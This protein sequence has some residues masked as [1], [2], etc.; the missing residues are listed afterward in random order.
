[1]TD[2]NLDNCIVENQ[3][4]VNISIRSHNN[5]HTID[6]VDSPHSIMVC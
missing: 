4:P 1:M 5:H 3:V 6:V 2:E